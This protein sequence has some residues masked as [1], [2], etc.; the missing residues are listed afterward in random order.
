MFHQYHHV[1]VSD[2]NFVDIDGGQFES[3]SCEQ[4]SHVGDVDVGTEMG[5]DASGS[6]QFGKDEG[7]TQ[8][9]EGVAAGESEEETSVGFEDSLDVILR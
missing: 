5:G 1:W 2:G 3:R 8:F 6:F 7:G 4:S 9:R